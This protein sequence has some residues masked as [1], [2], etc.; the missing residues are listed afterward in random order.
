MRYI[1]LGRTKIYQIRIAGV[2]HSR[3][4][5]VIDS[6]LIAGHDIGRNEIINYVLKAHVGVTTWLTVLYTANYAVSQGLED[7]QAAFMKAWSNPAPWTAH[8]TYFSRT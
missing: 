3:N 8:R 2:N 5:S 1:C 4:H 7:F 6:C